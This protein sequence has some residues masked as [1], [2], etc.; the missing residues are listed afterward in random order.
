MIP[1]QRQQR[2]VLHLY[3]RHQR[4]L[5]VVHLYII[6]IILIQHQQ[7]PEHLRTRDR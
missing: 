7:Q 5:N 6:Q 1:R 4:I 2:V 3:Q